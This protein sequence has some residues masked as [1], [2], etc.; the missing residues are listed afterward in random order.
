[1]DAK[2]QHEKAGMFGE[3]KAQLEQRV[4]RDP[5]QVTCWAIGFGFLMSALPI[6]R[7]LKIFIYLLVQI[8]KPVLLVLGLMKLSEEWKKCCGSCGNHGGAE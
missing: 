6:V 2:T 4:R 3:Y 8:I 5:T 7:L 1:M